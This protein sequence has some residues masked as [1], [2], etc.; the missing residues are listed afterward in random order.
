M[1]AVP[2]RPVA[3]AGAPGADPGRPMGSLAV[4]AGAGALTMVALCFAN[5]L[6]GGGGQAFAQSTEALKHTFG[7]NDAMLGIVPF[8]V[9]IAGNLGAVPIAA[10]CARHRRTAVLAAMFVVWGI[11]MAL[12]GLAPVFDV[13]GIAAGF[14]VF[15]ALRIGSSLLEATD[16]ATLPLI[17]DWWPVEARAQKVSIFNAGAAV[18]TFA[19]LVG[20]GV[21]VD[22]FGWRWAFVAWLPIALVGAALMR[23]RVEPRRGGQDA[24]YSDRLEAATAGPEHDLV[25]ELVEHEAPEIAGIVS[26]QVVGDRWAVI[27][28]V[29]RM[30]S[31]RL[32]AL[33]LAVTG[34]TGNG[35]MTWGL[36][37]FKRTFGLSGAQAGALAPVLG[38]GALLG[39]LGGGFLSDKLLSRGML[40]ARVDVTSIGYLGAGVVYF[41]AFTTTSL[42]VAAPLL[43]LASTLATLPMGPQFALLMDV[44]PSPLRSQASAAT[45]VLQASGS[46]GALLVGFTSTL[47]HENLRLALLCFSPFYL[48]GGAL[49]LAARRT[50][51]ADVALV[52]AEARGHTT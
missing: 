27:R 26:S 37:Y 41:V 52:V 36:A 22:D 14:V 48:L 45:N 30:R 21:I 6:Q 3:P 20:A 43:A 11:L 49:V 2:E 17:A 33:G 7:V 24:D 8:G 31:W 9:A 47:L 23:S 28:A 35:V 29:A 40:H 16:P 51:V 44:T 25:V 13:V 34:I 38:V 4:G 46:L 32:A 15:G 50:Y 1:T 10:L 19:G 5:G 39:I 12:A 18:G 42:A